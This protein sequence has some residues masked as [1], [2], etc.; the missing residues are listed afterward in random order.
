V[1]LSLE[2]PTPLTYFANLVVSDTEFPLLETAISLAQDMQPDLDI[3]SVLGEVDQLQDQLKKYIPT[4]ATDLQKLRSLNQ[5][6]FRDKGFAI[7][8]NDYDKPSNY[9][10]PTLLETRQGACESLAVLWM[11]LAQSVGLQIRG[12]EFSGHFL[13]MVNLHYGV[14]I[15]DPMT[16]KSLSHEAVLERLAP[17]D[18]DMSLKRFVKAMDAARPRQIIARMLRNLRIIY[19]I[20]NDSDH[21]LAVQQR[22]MV[23][24]Q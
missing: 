22:L 13:L 24:L 4:G 9:Y 1:K 7:N 8:L 10:L 5:F 18:H 23:L 17:D 19:H 11:E 20:E 3:Q 15:I 12:V 2:T 14:A 6:F 21:L 16:G